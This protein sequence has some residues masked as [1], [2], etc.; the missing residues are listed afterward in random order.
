MRWP[1]S[2]QDDDQE[3][4]LS[5]SKREDGSVDW[6]STL[7]PRNL[8]TSAAV[9]ATSLL[10][11]RFYKSYVRRIPSVNYI[12]PTYFRRKSLFGKVTRVGDADNFHLF[13][14]PGGRLTGWGWLPWRKV[15]TSKQGLQSNTIHIRIAGVDAPELSHFGK[16]AQPYGQEAFEWLKDYILD[17][18]VRAYIYR[19]DQYDR[20]VATVTVRR[21]LFRKDVG[22]EMLKNGLAT[23]Y[24]AKTGSEF[25]EFEGKYRAAEAKAKANKVGMWSGRS[26]LAQFFNKTKNSAELESPRAYKDRMKAAEQNA[27]QDGKSAKGKAAGKK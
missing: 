10:L 2:K 6:D 5:W 8:A 4:F 25:G 18:R 13:H 12:K 20:V 17:R 27:A 7:T 14:T 3:S 1:W 24:E 26:K 15:P 11:I 16:P 9:T 23:V 19:R 22:L 21:G